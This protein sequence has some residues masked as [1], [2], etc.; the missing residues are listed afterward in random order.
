MNTNKINAPRITDTV[1]I[2]DL[3]ENIKLFKSDEF[4]EN[5]ILNIKITDRI[6]YD[7]EYVY[8]ITNSN[9]SN[10]SYPIEL[11][12]SYKNSLDN[13]ISGL[14]QN[15]QKIILDNNNLFVNYLKQEKLKITFDQDITKIN[16]LI[17]LFIIDKNYDI[18]ITCSRYDL[19][20]QYN[21]SLIYIDELQDKYVGLNKK[22][23]DITS[24]YNKICSEYDALDTNYKILEKKYQEQQIE[25]EKYLDYKK[26]LE[27]RDQYY[28]YSKYKLEFD[29]K[30]VGFD[31]Q[32]C[33]EFSRKRLTE[34]ESL[35]RS[36]DEFII[37]YLKNEIVM[38]LIPS[39]TYNF[40]W[41]TNNA[42]VFIMSRMTNGYIVTISMDYFKF[43][44]PPNIIDY[45]KKILGIQNLFIPRII[46][47]LKMIKTTITTPE[48]S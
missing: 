26:L 36:Q 46:D 42:T 13:I 32:F 35:I 22:H 47:I 8:H 18:N 10:K 40:I 23:D 6:N 45:L 39:R 15:I 37:I 19:V 31:I 34:F 17:S 21:Q 7:F 14:E 38:G 41:I 9:S 11:K 33:E 44:I 1:C 29:I 4:I 43:A 48:I 12:F 24:K 16:L 25:I 2:K 20:T 27:K 5:G 3:N 28:D 30:I